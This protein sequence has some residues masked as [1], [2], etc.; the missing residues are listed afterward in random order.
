MSFWFVAVEEFWKQD[1]AAPEYLKAAWLL[2]TC[3]HG[4]L[5]GLGA[6]AAFL[7]GVMGWELLWI[8]DCKIQRRGKML[9][10]GWEE[11]A[12]SPALLP[13]PARQAAGTCVMEAWGI[14]CLG[15]SCQRGE[16]ALLPLYHSTKTWLIINWSQKNM[17]SLS[18][19]SLYH[20]LT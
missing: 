12:P 18:M 5:V 13:P 7:P 3:V 10:L 19:P 14:V 1:A 2:F 15:H 20:S 6:L 9:P 4:C 8:G 16:K 17:Q 11:L